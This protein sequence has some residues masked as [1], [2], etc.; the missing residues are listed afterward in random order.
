VDVWAE[1]A[2]VEREQLV[3]RLTQAEVVHI[4]SCLDDPPASRDL[5]EKLRAHIEDQFPDTLA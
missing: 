5:A 2:K 1:L 4:L 3:V